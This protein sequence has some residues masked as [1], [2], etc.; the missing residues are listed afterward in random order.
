MRCARDTAN[1][2]TAWLISM[3]V[4]PEVR[5]RGVGGL[6]VDGV[7]DWARSSGVIRLLLDVSDSNAP[8][9]AL[10]ARKGFTPNGEVG[11]LPPPREHIREHQRELRL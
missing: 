5:R 8:A 10:Y 3:W 11:T 2:D 6:L 4:A 1:T 7:V 9:I